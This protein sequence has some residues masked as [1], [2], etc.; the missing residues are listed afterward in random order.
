MWCVCL[1][2]IPICRECYLC[3]MFLLHLLSYFERSLTQAMLDL[4]FTVSVG[5]D[6]SMSWSRP[7]Y[8]DP[9]LFFPSAAVLSKEVRNGQ[10]MLL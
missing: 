5:E 8:L 6:I 3:D 4:K 1:Y 2:K 7:P 9:L 10:N